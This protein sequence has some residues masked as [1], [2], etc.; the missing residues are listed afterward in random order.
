MLD[1]PD[2]VVVF[3]FAVVAFIIGWAMPRGKYLK[4]IQLRFFKALHNFFADEEEYIQNKVERVRKI[5][6]RRKK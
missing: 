3:Y 5:A 1:L 4:A 2:Y 6:T